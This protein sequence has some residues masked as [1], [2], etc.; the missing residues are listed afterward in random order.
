MGVHS[1]V[2]PVRPGYNCDL[3]RDSAAASALPPRSITSYY[4]D[5]LTILTPMSAHPEQQYLDLMR[6]V[7]EHGAKK[8]DRTGTGTRSVFGWQS[9]YDLAKG[10]QLL[11]TKKLRAF[12][13]RIAGL[14]TKHGSRSGS[15]TV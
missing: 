12:G 4:F 2:R 14:P 15:G 10:F 5:L 7:L 1:G 3:A 8:S 13:Q 9:R 6:H 11:T